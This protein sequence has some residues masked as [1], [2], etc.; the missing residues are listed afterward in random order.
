[1]SLTRT[2]PA[3]AML[4]VE[5]LRRDVRRPSVKQLRL[6]AK[7]LG[8]LRWFSR[9]G[10]SVCPVGLHPAAT[11]KYRED[12]Y[13]D[14]DSIYKAQWLEDLLRPDDETRLTHRRIEDAFCDFLDW[15]DEQRDA[16][17]AVEAVWP[18]R[19]A[20]VA[21]LRESGGGA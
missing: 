21:R 7:E 19:D 5:V 8:V 15:W 13:L 14:P 16:A 2:I 17:A 18:R 4:V 6:G 3:R 9:D 10:E 11:S 1:M 12:I 20:R